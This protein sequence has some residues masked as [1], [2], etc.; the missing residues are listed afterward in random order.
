MGIKKKKPQVEIDKFEMI[1]G[2]RK[3]MI[4]T[5][6]NKQSPSTLNLGLEQEVNCEGGILKSEFLI[7]NI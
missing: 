7:N 5:V 1:W 3:K 6:N 2:N 4:T